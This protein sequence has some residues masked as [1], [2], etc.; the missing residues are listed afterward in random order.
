MTARMQFPTNFQWGAATS[1]YQIEGGV[2]DDGRSSS[3]W[4]VFSHTPGK[5][6]NHDTGDIACDAYHRWKEDV[7]WMKQ[8]GLK[9][10]RFSIAWPRIIPAGVGKINQPGMDYYSRLVDELLA[11]GILPLV[12]LYHWDLPAAISGGWLSRS[13]A[14]AFVD[15][16]AVVVRALGDRVKDWITINE[17]FCASILGYTAGIHAPGH[18][19]RTEGLAAA[20]HLLLAHGMAVPVIREECPNARVGIALNLTPYYTTGRSQADLA[21]SRHADGEV[22]RWFLDPLYGRGY[23]IDMLNDYIRLGALTSLQP[24]FI[25]S[26]DL[27][28]IA[29]PTDFLGVNYYTRN[30]VRAGTITDAGF[31]NVES[32]PAPKD[33]ATDMGWELFPFGLYEILSRV[34]WEYKPGDILVTEN[35]ASYSD[36]PDSAG[37]IHDERRIAYLRSH[38]AAVGRAIQSGVPVTGYYLWSLLDNFEW[39]QGYS[40]RFGIVYV[41]FDS[42]KRYPKDSAFW[43][44]QVIE[45]NGLPEI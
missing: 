6:A 31:V 36:G 17:P 37:K 5:I 40:Q 22:N 9:A 27:D 32:L 20:H 16:S 26:K 28:I 19:D 24:D 33:N 23:P 42:Q 41:D 44:R 45:Q 11:A 35:G 30:V 21:A 2:K 8:L 14:E 43:Y 12:T 18:R 7:A 3:I 4:D 1:S 25:Q 13:T 29:V 10:Y 39:N 34:H 38:I 15:Y